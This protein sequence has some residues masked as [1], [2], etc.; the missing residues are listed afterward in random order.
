MERLSNKK[1]TGL[2]GNAL[3]TWG[4]LF[5]AAGVLGRGIIKTH[6]LGIG[7]VTAQQLLDIMSSSQA[8]MMFATLSLVLQAMETCA[9]PV[10]A[11]LL[12]EGVQHTSDFKRY[13]L[14]ITGL[15]VLSEIPYNLALGGRL[16]DFGS[17]NPV[18]GLVLCLIP[19][20]FYRRYG[21]K[22]F[23]NVLI[24]IMV[25]AAAVV[26]GQ[27]LKIDAGACMVLVV[28][29]LWAFRK[30]P[31]YRNFAGAAVTVVC[32]LISPFFLAAPMGFLVVH[33]YNGEKGTNSRMV[34]YLAYPAILLIA[35]LVGVFLFYTSS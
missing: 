32:S 4:L 10:F 29:V 3:R 24:R 33:L 23:R 26:W 27:M 11:L 35:G 19:L 2:N 34:N 8:A 12:V 6:M 15:A 7:K 28:A 20:Y 31:L 30:K 14:R 16:L 22:T 13:F 5:M 21:D 1:T 17:R 18:F 25:T 9:A